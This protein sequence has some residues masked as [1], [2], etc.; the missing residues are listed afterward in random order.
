M[1]EIKH[2]GVM[3]AIA[4]P[5][6]TLCSYA[7]V[8]GMKYFFLYLGTLPLIWIVSKIICKYMEWNK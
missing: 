6:S 3:I 2:L 8:V 1:K 5:V 4:L 7:D